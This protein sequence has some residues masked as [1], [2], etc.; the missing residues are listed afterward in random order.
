MPCDNPYEYW[1]EEK[2]QGKGL[3]SMKHTAVLCE[4]ICIKGCH[5]CIESCIVGAI[6]EE[7][8]VQNLCRNNA[9]G[10]TKRVFDTVECNVCRIIFH[11]RYGINK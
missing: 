2:L 11:M 3:I 4:N 7:S 8:V 9:Y 6:Q 10:K 1:D 5:K